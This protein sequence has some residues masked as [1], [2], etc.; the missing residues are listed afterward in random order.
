MANLH[1]FKDPV[2]NVNPEFLHG[3][4]LTSTKIH[5]LPGA[6]GRRIDNEV[7]ARLSSLAGLTPKGED[8]TYYE[9]I[10][11]VYHRPTRSF[12][13][14]FRETMDAFLARQRDPVKYPEWLMKSPEK[15]AERN[16]HIYAVK[17]HPSQVGVLRSH[18]DWLEHIT[19]DQTFDALAYFL[20]KSGVVKDQVV[21]R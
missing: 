17:C 5:P 8:V 12:Y 13:V 10:A 2:R 15:Q 21:S 3:L 19:N 14:A 9:H 6:T 11:T 20:E 1:G 4:E 16:I 7:D 18:E